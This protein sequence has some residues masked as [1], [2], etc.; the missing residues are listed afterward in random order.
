MNKEEMLQEIR[1]YL[2]QHIYTNIDIM[3]MIL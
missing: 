3:L 1:K 2:V